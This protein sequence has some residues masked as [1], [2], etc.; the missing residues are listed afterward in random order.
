MR[1]FTKRP[2]NRCKD[3]GDTW[4][5]KG[6]NISNR[7]PN[8]GSSNVVLAGCG[9]RCLGAIVLLLI[10]GACGVWILGKM[11][12]GDSVPSASPEPS[13]KQVEK[14]ERT[15]LKKVE[16]TA[17]TTTAPPPTATGNAAMEKDSASEFLTLINHD[18]RT[19]KAKYVTMTA[20]SVVVKRE[21]GQTFEIQ[22]ADLKIESVNELKKRQ[23]EAREQVKQ[24]SEK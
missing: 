14:Q 3:C 16:A 15:T 5:P 11:I 12:H 22:L 17:A 19:L 7:C 8:C 2:R 9:C 20:N 13:K 21:D 4:F 18:G 6:R 23:L 10:I 24:G 1:F